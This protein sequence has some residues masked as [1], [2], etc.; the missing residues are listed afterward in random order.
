MEVLRVAAGD[1]ARLKQVRLAAL[2]EAPSAFGSSYDAE[3]GRPDAEWVQ[4]AVAGSHGS[5]RATFFARRDDEVV[6]LVGGYRTEP[7]ASTVELVSM[8]VAPL[9]RGRG[10]GALL[11]DAVTSWAIDTDASSISLWVTCGN[12]PA[13]RLYES[14]HFVPTGELRPRPSDPAANEARMVRALR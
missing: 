9:V 14:K 5:D 1:A 8:W 12:T 11:V 2:E 13:E 4:R 3:A 6:G 7:S 10:V